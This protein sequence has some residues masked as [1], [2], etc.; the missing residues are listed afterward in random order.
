M[1]K[2]IDLQ[3]GVAD[4]SHGFLQTELRDLVAPRRDV[5]DLMFRTAFNDL[6]ECPLFPHGGRVEEEGRD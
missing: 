6:S 5:T 2:T 1:A 3:S 4:A